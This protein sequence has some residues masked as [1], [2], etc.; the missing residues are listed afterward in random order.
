VVIVPRADAA[1]PDD[2]AASFARW[3]ESGRAALAEGLAGAKRTAEATGERLVI[4]PRVGTL[5]SDI[6]GVLNLIRSHEDIGVLFDPVALLAPDSFR[7]AKDSL[8]RAAEIVAHAAAGIDA[9]YAANDMPAG[10][11]AAWLEPVV[12]AAIEARVP[13]CRG[14]RMGA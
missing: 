10:V 1:D 3:G 8:A 6:P 9:V 4:W 12:A 7:F 2:I 13:V 5:V 14:P 11:D